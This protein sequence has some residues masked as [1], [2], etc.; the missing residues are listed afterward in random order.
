MNLW[1]VNLKPGT[2]KMGQL[3]FTDLDI[4]SVCLTK[5]VPVVLIQY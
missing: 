4:S 1:T 2:D 3:I 5:K